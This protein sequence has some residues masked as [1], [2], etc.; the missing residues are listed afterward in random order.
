[1]LHNMA[2]GNAIAKRDHRQNT[3]NLLKQTNSAA[4]QVKDIRL[5]SPPHTLSIIKNCDAPPVLGG[6]VYNTS[7]HEYG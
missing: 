7:V 6:Q 2:I 5:R 1:M 4:N 3:C